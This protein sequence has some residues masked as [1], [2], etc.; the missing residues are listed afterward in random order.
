MTLKGV[1]GYFFFSAIVRHAARW[2]FLC[3]CRVFVIE[4]D[5]KKERKE[6]C[7]KSSELGPLVNKMTEP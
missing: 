5:G 3:R 1:L 2:L 4:M 7:E 6:R